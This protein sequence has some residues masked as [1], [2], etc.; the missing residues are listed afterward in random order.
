MTD[1]FMDDLW[2]DTPPEERER[3]VAEERDRFA[4]A[5]RYQCFYGNCVW[6]YDTEQGEIFGGMGEA[7]C[8]CEDADENGE[9]ER[10]M[11][12]RKMEV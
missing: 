2:G 1:G 12:W 4:A 8:P 9:D 10:F 6:F 3:L 5:E 11:L 7:G